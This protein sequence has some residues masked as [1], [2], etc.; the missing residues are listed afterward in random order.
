MQTVMKTTTHT[1]L[2]WFFYTAILLKYK[3]RKQARKESNIANNIDY[4][5]RWIIFTQFHNLQIAFTRAHNKNTQN[6]YDGTI[7]TG[8]LIWLDV[9]A[10]CVSALYE[11]ILNST[12][13]PKNKNQQRVNLTIKKFCLF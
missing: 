6:G 13:K 4:P 9:C 5:V 1:G 2:K 3:E 10:M 7:K 8:F 12:K 11:Q